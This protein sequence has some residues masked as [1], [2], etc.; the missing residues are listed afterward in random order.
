MLMAIPTTRAA[1][2]GLSNAGTFS[3]GSPFQ[4][5]SL[6]LTSSR[7]SVPVIQG[8]GFRLVELKIK[9][10]KTLNPNATLDQQRETLHEPARG[11][12]LPSGCNGL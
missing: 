8:L 10:P 2:A 9:L 12:E 6:G 4:I 11:R 3:C 1:I 7:V 5:S